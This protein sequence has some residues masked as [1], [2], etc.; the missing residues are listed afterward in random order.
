MTVNTIYML[1]L[2][3]TVISL[4][5]IVMPI[6]IGVYAS[7]D[8][9]RDEGELRVAFFGLP[10]FVKH[11]KPNSVM[12]KIN[13]KEEAGNDVNKNDKKKK[14]GKLAAAVKSF[15]MS[16]AVEIVKR[17]RIRHLRLV[18]IIG[19]GDAAITA[20]I[21]GTM[22]IACAQAGAYFGFHGEIS[23]LTPNYD[24]ERLDLAFSGIFSITT[25]DIIYAVCVVLIKKIKT[26]CG[27]H[28][29]ARSVYGKYIAG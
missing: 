27:G 24:S 2:V 12:K 25:A 23:N 5:L 20:F 10:I 14:V 6:V 19:T 13:V 16:V 18:G 22:K 15:A 11:I 8:T 17:I 7:V 21:V 1:Y 4:H 26:K 9:V 28:S 29:G 3:L